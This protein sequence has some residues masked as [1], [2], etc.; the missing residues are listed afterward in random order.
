MMKKS[1]KKGG[2]IGKNS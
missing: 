2:G 1:V